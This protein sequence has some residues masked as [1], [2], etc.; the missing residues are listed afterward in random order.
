M[1]VATAGGGISKFDGL[2][3]TNY[4][5][6]S[7]IS[8]NIVKDLC[9]D[10]DGN[11]WSA[12]SWGGITRYNGRK[13]L[14][15][16]SKDGLGDDGNHNTLLSDH[17]GRLW[18]GGY[19]GVTV[20]ENGS[21]K[22]FSKTKI[23]SEPIN[24]I[25]Q[26]SK[27]NIWIGG[28]NGLIF[29]TESDTLL[30]QE[31]D[32][33]PSN[34]IYSIC[35]DFEGN[36]L[37]GSKNGISKLLTGSLG[38]RKDYKFEMHKSIP[39]NIS[40]PSILSDREKNIWITTTNDGLYILKY[41]DTVIHITKENGLP[42]NSLSV[43]YEDRL[44]N[45]WIGSNGGGLIKYA[46]KAFL[47]YKNIK[48]LN[49]PSIFSIVQ[50]NN[51][52]IWVAT[53]EDG[54]FVYNGYKTKQYSIKNGL[55]SNNIR[56]IVKDAKGYIWLATD[57]GLV[58]YANGDFKTY[59][60]KDGLPIN[61]IRVLLVDFEDN[62]WVGTY[63]GGLSKFENGGFKTIT[64]DDGLSHNYIHALFQD[65]KG[66]IWAGTGNGV[67]KIN[68]KGVV[69]NYSR[70]K[71]FC[72]PY[73]GS[74]T[75]DNFGNIWFG[76]DR[77]IVRY[78]GID[79]KSMTANDGLSSGVIYLLHKDRHGNI[80]VGTNNGIDKI[81]LNSYGQIDRIKNYKAEQGFIGIECNTR[82]IYEGDKGNIWIG[83]VKGL[84]KY[85]PKEDKANVFEPTLHI[86]KIK[87]YQENVDWLG[88]SKE[89]TKWDNLPIGL[90]LNYNQNHIT[91]E[92]SAINLTNPNDIKYKYRL[93]PFDKNWYEVTNKNS[94]TYS[95]LPPGKYTFYVKSKNNDNVWNQKPIEYQ[96]TITAPFWKTWWFYF[97]IAASFFYIIYKLSSYKEKQQ[98]A[99]SKELELKVKERTHLI[100]TQRDEK[101]VLL[102]EIHHRVKNNL[103]VINSLLSI[104]SSYTDDKRALELFDEAKNRIRS[105][106]LIHEKMYQTED[107]AKIDFQDYI[108][109][110]TDDLIQTY[111]INCDIFLDIKID[112]VKFDI[113]TLI[114]IGLLL[115]EIISNTLKYAFKGTNKG[116]I[117]IHLI[118]DQE[119]NIY[120]LTV[121]DNGIGI[122]EE[123]FL[124][125]DG[126]LGMELIKIFVSQLDGEI[127]L[128][129][130]KGSIF[131]IVFPPRK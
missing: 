98:I 113:D 79:F 104:Q 61:N 87:L 6:K 93:E 105:M 89:L 129:K 106:A 22:K 103:Q 71:D 28:N 128:L 53:S 57:N 111:S 92:F 46:N 2:V 56:S 34:T 59:T 29:I 108:V 31:K 88:Y 80:W 23:S 37:L 50:D 10:K 131:K 118:Y 5:E 13:F 91:F 101:E 120:T 49:S 107:L 124:T 110:L 68:P 4:N 48:G 126:S 36:I 90:N 51:E 95:N 78:D 63:G 114:P 127:E 25:Y 8:G 30:I 99:I 96:F 82:A 19:N 7:G 73:V 69:R 65:K 32:G 38:H 40:V 54:A 64:Q 121:G 27:N 15:F 123:V 17:L 81:T 1:W 62:L 20:Y 84:I 45:I 55:P 33:L 47:S 39:K 67:N 16:D 94:A 18:I 41:D 43:V 14:T 75:E 21:F 83:T 60:T 42:T 44:S 52:N 70:S 112:N 100:E 119:K 12:S 85:N 109:A 116:K 125:E 9:E 24:T 117:I 3:F 58:K 102:K 97:I 122:S 77:C 74:I 72:N 35:E 86:N 76:T 130:Q 11:I 115:N 66:N 26:D